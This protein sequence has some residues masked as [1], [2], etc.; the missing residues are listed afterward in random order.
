M[1]WHA[2]SWDNIGRVTLNKGS[3]I[4]SGSENVKSSHV[5]IHNELAYTSVKM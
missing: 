3:K 1:G 5:M 2:D 4:G